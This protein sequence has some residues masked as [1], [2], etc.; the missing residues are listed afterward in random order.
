[1]GVIVIVLLIV[2]GLC[3]V[4][5]IGALTHQTIGTLWKSSKARP[6]FIAAVRSVRTN[7]YPN[8]VI[9][10]YV[11]TFLL[12]T[13]IYPH[14][15]THVRTIWDISMPPATGVFEIKEH[16]AAIGLAILPA[17]RYTWTESTQAPALL[18]RVL[19]LMLT[20]IVWYNFLT[21]HILN[22]VRGL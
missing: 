17:Y 15:R 13:L 9:A 6:G 2:H 1:M 5:L 3:A 10:I 20:V 8:A 16:F 4:L 22:N 18:R 7:A 11:A 21:G 12:G 14:F 19:T